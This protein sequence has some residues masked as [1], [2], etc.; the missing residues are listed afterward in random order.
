VD[1]DGNI[2]V[3]FTDAWEIKRELKDTLSIDLLYAQVSVGPPDT[4]EPA[5][6]GGLTVSGVDN[7]NVTLD[8]APNTEED[9][10]GYRV[11]RSAGGD[12]QLVT[13]QVLSSTTYTDATPVAGDYYYFVTAVDLSGNE[14]APSAVVSA[15]TTEPSC[16]VR[17]E[18]IAMALDLVD[19]NWQAT[20][21]VLITDRM[22]RPKAGATVYGDWYFKGGIT[23]SGVSALTD[24]TGVAVLAS[25][26]QRRTKSGDLFTFRVTDVVMPGCPYDSSLNNVTEGSVAA[27]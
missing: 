14:S 26:A 20:A 8:W 2:F 4:Q 7:L 17:V 11:Y 25:P 3:H 5:A 1:A 24:A 16:F 15:T 6:P 18:S 19:G 22:A 10:A 13:A 23:Q 9:L 27:P 21:A 12:Y